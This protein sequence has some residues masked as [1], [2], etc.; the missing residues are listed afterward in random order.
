MLRFGSPLSIGEDMEAEPVRAD[1]RWLSLREP[2]DGAARSRRLASALRLCPTATGTLEVH[3]LGGGSG[4]MARWLARQLPGVQHW[5]IHDRDAELLSL[6]GDPPPG[7]ALDGA[8]VTV[9]TRLGDVSRLGATALAGVSLVTASAL[10]DMLTRPE[11][12]RVLDVAAGAHCP[13]LLA[14]SVTGEVALD[15]PH[16]LD[17]D[18]ARAFNDH[19]RRPTGEGPRLGPGAWAAAAETLTRRGYAVRFDPT[20]WHL[21]P[22][23]T[24]VARAWFDGWLG[25]ACEQDPSLV[26]RAAHYGSLRRTQLRSGRLT[27]VVQHRDLLALPSHL[28][29]PGSRGARH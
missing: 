8:P 28:A 14:L 7:P 5:V 22:D 27:V 1:A 20:P 17:A 18:V 23:D 2:V 10:L 25:A 12:D 15:P 6:V 19:Q 9:D 21:G 26:A 29:R 3:D 13:V 24:A 16:P 11:L 4:S